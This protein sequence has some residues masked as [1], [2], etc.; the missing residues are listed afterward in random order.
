MKKKFEEFLLYSF[1]NY[2]NNILKIYDNILFQ[3]KIKI[4]TY[5]IIKF[6]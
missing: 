3:N 4:I 2:F 6:K 5:N 1:Y